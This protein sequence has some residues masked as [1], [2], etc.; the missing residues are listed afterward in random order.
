MGWWNATK[1][2][3]KVQPA[4]EDL[5]L[6]FLT[7]LGVDVENSDMV[8][9]I[10]PLS[11]LDS[12]L[13]D[14][15][16]ESDLLGIMP[17]LEKKFADY[18]SKFRNTRKKKN[19]KEAE[20][21]SRLDDIYLVAK[22]LFPRSGMYLAHEDGNNTDDTYYRYEVIYSAGKKT[23]INCF[24]SY[25]DDINVDAE[26]PREKGTEKCEEKLSAVKPDETIIN[27]LI[28]KASEEGFDELIQRLRGD[29][30]KSADTSGKKKK[31]VV[32]AIPGLK[33]VKGIV[34]KYTGQSKKLVIPEE[35]TEI[36][37]KAFYGNR[38]LR[39]IVLPESLERLGKSAFEDCYELRKIDIPDS[40]KEI[41][42]GAFMGCGRLPG[43]AVPEGVLQISAYTFQD[44]MSLQDVILP[45]TL[46]EIADDAFGSCTSLK[47]I[48]IPEDVQKIGKMA[49]GYCRNLTQITIP[50]GLKEIGEEAFKECNKL[51]KIIIPESVEAIGYRFAPGNIE[52]HISN[53]KSWLSLKAGS[54][55]YT[56]GPLRDSGKLFLNGQAVEDL[57]IPS[58]V[59][60]IRKSVFDGYR[61]L[62]SLVIPESVS[63]IEKCAFQCC[64]NLVKVT[65]PKTLEEVIE[66]RKVFYGC[67]KLKDI[68]YL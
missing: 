41:G 40:V 46:K 25:G 10:G 16:V 47:T 64:S 62:K 55:F 29:S 63:D 14:G 51:E 48:V 42:F 31:E 58:D 52:I 23:E 17:S 36:G 57:V 27:R 7:V 37:E 1:I 4:N 13:S 38:Y 56:T 19:K 32:K 20:P 8:E 68:Q 50:D 5:A 35:I 11:N 28:E 26:N 18:Q 65:A 61:Y 45:T 22:K 30:G 66:E 53:L 21:A 43:I 33:V 60:I 24:Y 44:C 12:Y 39:E 54:V 6:Q 9:E 49:F 34:K 67:E 3:L 15:L 59:Q 2:G